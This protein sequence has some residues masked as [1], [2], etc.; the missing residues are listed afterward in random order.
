MR[1]TVYCPHYE[2]LGGASEVARRLGIGLLARGHAVGFVVRAPRGTQS[3]LPVADPATGAEL[4]RT[5]LVQTPYWG[6]GFGA[7]RRF[8]RRFPGDALGLLRTMRGTRPELIATHCSKF[9]APYV[10]AMR[11]A[12]RCPI[13]IHLHNAG[14]T[15]DGPESIALTRL[16]LRCATRVIAVSPE[17]AEYARTCLPRRAE[18]VVTVPNGTE[19]AE[20]LAV[21]P[22]PRPRPYVLGVGRLAY[23][24]GFDVLVD[25]FA[26]AAVDLDLVFAGDGPERK[27]LVERAAM[28][29]I[30]GRTHFLGQLDRETVIGLLRGA[31]I[32]AAPSRFEGH[33]LVHLEAMAAGAPLIASAIPGNPAELR[34]GQTGVLVPPDDPQ[35]LAGALRDLARMPERARALGEAARE[36]ARQ[37]LN[38]SQVTDRVLAVYASAAAATAG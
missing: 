27:A 3:R 20:L 6:A 30:S 16:I 7:F 31:S 5:R 28:R 2:T 8:A 15:A 11:M 13:V 10:L 17:V 22:T 9:H 23:Q 32:V 14:R 4:R 21:P 36:A 18:R 24:K 38:W 29:S 35:A 26:E 12:I 1:I 25:A 33:P 37:F 34:S 19:T